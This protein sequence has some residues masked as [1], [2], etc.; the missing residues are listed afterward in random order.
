[1]VRIALF[2]SLL[3]TTL[4]AIATPNGVY[5]QSVPD[6]PGQV[7]IGRIQNPNLPPAQPGAGT[8]R[9]D[10]GQNFLA[11]FANPSYSATQPE[12]VA[13][14][15]HPDRD[16]IARLSVDHALV[17]GQPA[18]ALKGQIP[19]HTVALRTGG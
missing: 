5:A 1:M 12:M 16:F 6:N 17:A 14:D 3:A 15:S 18:T 2:P 4:V 11:R 13:A 9:N 8:F 19:S 7:W 10:A